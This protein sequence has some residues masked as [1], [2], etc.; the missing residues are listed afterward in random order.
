MANQL[1]SWRK[2]STANEWTDLAYKAGTSVGYLNLIA[3]GYRNA[4]P[5]LALAIEAA[6]KSFADK[7]V[8]TKEQLVFKVT[9]QG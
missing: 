5:R 2:S 7:P 9:P 1:L 3:Y 4:S 8:I 6:S